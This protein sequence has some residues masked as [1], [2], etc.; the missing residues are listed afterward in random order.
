MGGGGVKQGTVIH[1]SN[2]GLRSLKGL[3][4]LSQYMVV[5]NQG[6]TDC[7]EAHLAEQ[8]IRRLEGGT[9]HYEV[10]R[11]QRMLNRTWHSR[12]KYGVSGRKLRPEGGVNKN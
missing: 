1:Q 9:Q 10:I 4:D 2:V 11:L 7:Y 8:P 5:E 6:H 3:K 12:S